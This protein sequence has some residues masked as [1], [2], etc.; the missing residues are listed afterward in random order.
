MKITKLSLSLVVPLIWAHAVCAQQIG[1]IGGK[2]LDENRN[3]LVGA[4]VSVADTFRGT[5]TDSEGRFVIA[6]GSDDRLVVSYLGYVAQ[7]CPVDSRD[8]IEI[9]MEPQ[10]NAIED[11]VVIG[12]GVQKRVNVTGAVSSIDYAEAAASR[13]VTSTAQVLQGMNAG[14]QVSQTSGQPGQEGMQLRI[15]G[16]GTLNDSSPLVIV[17]GFEGSIGNVNPD[18]IESVSIL[19]DAAS[20]AIYG[21]RG[22]N[23]VVLVT[24]KKGA[25]GKFNCSYSG[26]VAF[27][28]PANHFDVISNYADYMELMNESA[29]NIAG[30]RLFSQ[31]MIDLWR[32]KERD[33]RGIADSGYPN[34]VAYP[35]TDWMRA[36]FENNVYQKHNITASGSGGGTNYLLSF[37]YIDNP[38]V[39]ARTGMRKFQLRA[40]ISS[41]VT[42]WLEIGT[43]L[44][45]Y[46]STREL[47]NISG[48]SDYMSRAVPGIYPYYDGKYGW[49]ENPE[50]DSGARNNLYFINRFG[51]EQNIHYLNTSLFANVKL[52]LDIRYSVSFNYVRTGTERKYYGKTCNAFSFSQNDWAYR[53]E[54]LSK[55]NVSQRYGND[56]RWTFQNHLSWAGTFAGKHD[57]TAMIGFEA[58]YSNERN[59]MAQKNGF[60]Q[61]KLIE[62]DTATLASQIT[63][64]QTD[65]A[66]AS[67]F[68]RATYAYDNRYLFEMNLRYDGSSRF[69]R[70]SRWG[71]FPS[72]SAGWRI[73]QE[74]FMKDTGVD[75]L[76]L[77]ASWGRLGNHAIGNYEYL[78][79][80]ASGY[81]YSFG[82]KQSPGI[83][84]SLSNNLL[85]WETTTSTN[86]GL[87][88]GVL[89][90]RLTFETDIYHKVT[91]GILYKAPIFATVG[92]KSAPNQNLCEVTNT[93]FELTAGWRDRIKG[94]SYA[95]S[96]NF[97]RN[98][99]QV[100]KYKG[101]LQ[102]GWVTDENGIRR[103]WTN[104][105]DV[106]T[107]VGTTRRVMEGKLINEFYLL[108]T[109]RGDGSYFFGDGSVNPHGGPRDGMIRS[110]GDME[111]LR[112]MIAAGNTFLPNREIAKNKIWYGDYIYA[113]TNGDGIFGNENDYT[114]QDISMTPKFY[115]GFQIDLAWKGFDVSTS[116][117]GAG[118]FSIYWRYLGFNSYSTRG[119]TTIGRDIAYDH[120]FYDPENPTDPRTNLTSKHGRLTMNYGS[121]QNGGS[122]YST[123]WL[124][125][126]DYLKLKNLTIG[127]T[128][129]KKW[130]RKVGLHEVRVFFSG[131]NLWTITD[132]PGMDPEFSD[133]MNYY[134]SLKQYSIGLNL[135]F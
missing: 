21:N 40:N 106:T 47:N 8:H 88:L 132:Y 53:Y 92:N 115:Y 52:P 43:R 14:L 95:I 120:Y 68:G 121:E 133:T 45:G 19:K 38:G 69:A 99:N 122:N 24:T 91:D 16:I 71:L 101:R 28:R 83:V 80:Y 58:M 34:Y 63:G 66:T 41:Q 102:A 93:G 126:G 33:P 62:F 23:G 31:S 104:I 30:K 134:A 97:T 60:A 36:M 39:I 51:G 118:G 4:S 11:L 1:K 116:W 10:V 3:P 128:F 72:F 25:S 17:D 86:V 113:D 48:A 131:E 20:C 78:A 96:A 111:W 77:R 105:G 81:L 112:A 2:V 59:A 50:Q 65:F 100:S 90:N 13:P 56:Y 129:P 54:D 76:K 70:E 127:Y 87:E 108:N 44:W 46:E 119:N 49:M 42:R 6:A 27:M 22:A 125:R 82:G 7:E 73:S 61:D 114:F 55:L 35:N 79:T 107:D 85:E 75:N 98:Y 123:H 37:S 18:D 94:F 29:D 5:S 32:E 74:A 135:K 130:L 67:V 110:E 26:L 89:R 103:Y 84:A 9:V 15:R 12:Y 124:Y 64:T 57:V 117:A 109:Y